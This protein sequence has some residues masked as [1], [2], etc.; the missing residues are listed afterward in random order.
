MYDWRN[1]QTQQPGKVESWRFESFI[2]PEICPVG[3]VVT[4]R[5]DIPP[6]TGSIP[7]PGTSRSV[8]TEAS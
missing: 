1:W 5:F 6:Y 2:V 3:E 8:V 4:Q 7:V